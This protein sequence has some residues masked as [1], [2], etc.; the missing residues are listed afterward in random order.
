MLDLIIPPIVA[1]LVILSI[2]AYLG[3]HVIQRGVIFVDLRADTGL[4]Q[5]VF[6]PE[7]STESPARAGEIRSAQ[8]G[9]DEVRRSRLREA[10]LSGANLTG[11]QMQGV[12]LRKARARG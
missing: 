5:I 7:V 10:D 11:A 9:I 4:I 1:G 8:V 12:T 3:L 6:R 2:H